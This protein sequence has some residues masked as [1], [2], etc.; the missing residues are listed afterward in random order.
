MKFFAKIISLSALALV[1][2]HC[3]NDSG[4][5]VS[6]ITVTPTSVYI[7]SGVSSQGVDDSGN[8]WL[9]ISG[10]FYGAGDSISLTCDGTVLSPVTQFDTVNSIVVSV[11]AASSY[12]FCNFAVQTGGYATTFGAPISA[13]NI[14]NVTNNGLD[15]NPANLD[16][17]LDGGFYVAPLV[18]S[19]LSVQ[20]T[21]NGGATYF[22]PPI[23]SKTFNNQTQENAVVITLADPGNGNSEQC[24][25]FV[26]DTFTDPDN[27]IVT[28]PSP[29][30][31]TQINGI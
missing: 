3:S 30:Y 26:E 8:M 23:V 13:I 20:A 16:I 5:P 27:N 22:F 6:G 10:N 2:I 17:E 24:T 9:Q 11:P 29:G 4:G 14:L 12:N 28:V 25:F 21:C 18:N 31:S 15:I 19:T 7:I 1:N